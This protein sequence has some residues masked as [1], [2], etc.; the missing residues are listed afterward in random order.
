MLVVVLVLAILAT[1]QPAASIVEQPACDTT[2]ELRSVG[3]GTTTC[4]AE[5]NPNPS[6]GVGFMYYGVF[7]DRE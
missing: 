6:V 5:A 7:P 2:I 1:L 3:G 4:T